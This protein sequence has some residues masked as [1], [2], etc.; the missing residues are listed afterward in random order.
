M[1]NINIV[2]VVIFGNILSCRL[3]HVRNI[4]PR[5]TCKEI[6]FQIERHRTELSAVQC[7]EE[8]FQFCLSPTK[9]ELFSSKLKREM[10]KVLFVRILFCLDHIVLMLL[11]LINCNHKDI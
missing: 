11:D 8:T 9:K 10:K 1:F 4:Y 2:V 3:R 5:S 6:T 7:V